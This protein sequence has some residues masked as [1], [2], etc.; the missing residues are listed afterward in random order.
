[1]RPLYRVWQFWK[2]VTA[3]PLD[4]KA[5]AEI[6][7]VLSPEQQRLFGR[8][9]ASEQQH[10]YRVYETLKQAG[11]ENP[12]LLAAA[13]LHDVG[14]TRFP[15]PWWHRPFVV[16]GQA[17][18]RSK[19]AEWSQSEGKWIARPFVIKANHAEWGA[20]EAETAGSSATTIALIRYHHHPQT[21]VQD[22]KLANL[23]AHLQWADDNS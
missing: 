15:R 13:L 7:T 4:R 6:R 21:A 22:Q 14:K 10:S 23:L 8:F 3:R 11:Q 20:A 5:D 16:L 2:L 18:L 17:F 1:M 9:S 19:A 12:D